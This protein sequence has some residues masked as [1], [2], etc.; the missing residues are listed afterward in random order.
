MQ[1]PESREI[2]QRFQV[3]SPR[4][5]K[6]YALYNT[7]I[8][9]MQGTFSVAILI[10]NLLTHSGT[11]G[12]VV[13]DPAEYAANDIIKCEINGAKFEWNKANSQ[14]TQFNYCN[15]GLIKADLDR[16]NIKIQWSVIRP[17]DILVADGAAG[18][19]TTQAV[20]DFVTQLVGATGIE[21]KGSC[22]ESALPSAGSHGDLYVLSDFD[23]SYPGENIIGLA[24][25][26]AA[27]TVWNKVPIRWLQ[28]DGVT[29]GVN[30]LGQTAVKPGS[31]TRQLVSP[32]I[33]NDLTLAG[34]A[35]QPADL[36]SF[37][38][39]NT[40]QTIT[41]KKIYTAEPEIPS[42]IEPADSTHT[43]SPATE[44]QVALKQN[45]LSGAGLAEYTNTPGI[46]TERGITDA[47]SH[48]PLD[49]SS[50]NA[51]TE[52]A[53]KAALPEINDSVDY[54]SA[55]K[56][57]APAAKY[58]AGNYLGGQMQWV[59]PDTEPAAGSAVLVTSGGV[60][61]AILD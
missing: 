27:E 35:V 26:N 54:D 60:H 28:P 48:I 2:S 19:P 33:V 20:Y 36:A 30:T 44:A 23:L 53:V 50:A 18:T 31:I 17:L 34:T 57:Y 15:E 8:A 39:L 5:N 61:Q 45:R 24:V 11:A 16:Q 59:Q 13:L 41:G 4:D 12:E 10:E 1:L 14:S 55:V 9:E 51:V 3:R 58:N 29:I 7:G 6:F 21:Y 32:D 49:V 56:I 47:L 52:R 40:A 43:A 37:V 22:A 25:Y 46:L 42:K 38:T